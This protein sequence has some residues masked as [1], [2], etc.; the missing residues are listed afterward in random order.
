MLKPV[1]TAVILMIGF[2]LGRLLMA[3]E[4]GNIMLA[5][6]AALSAGE[7]L[8]VLLMVAIFLYAVM[9]VFNNAPVP[10]TE[11]VDRLLARRAKPGDKPADQS[12]D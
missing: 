12:F 3:T 7:L 9:I 11:T 4:Q 8:K 1:F 2:L 10:F 6:I 5:G